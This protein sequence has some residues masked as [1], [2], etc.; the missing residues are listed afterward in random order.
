MLLGK[1]V[2]LVN[3]IKLCSLMLVSGKF[4]EEEINKY[5]RMN[6]G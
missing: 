6:Y 2:I 1:I 3:K 5:M 4:Y